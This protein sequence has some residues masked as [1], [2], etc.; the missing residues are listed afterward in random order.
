[1]VHTR[2]TRWDAL[3]VSARVKIITI[4]NQKTAKQHQRF[5]I[6]SMDTDSGESEISLKGF[7]NMS[8]EI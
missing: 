3:A 5:L 6:I 8:C 2:V 4:T 1:V 7:H